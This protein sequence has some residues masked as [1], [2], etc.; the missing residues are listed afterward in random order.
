MDAKRNSADGAA[1]EIAARQHGVLTR[2]QIESCGLGSKAI[3][4]RVRKGQLHRVHQGVYAVGHPAT[5]LHR[6]WMA[7]VLACGMDAALSH[8]SAAVLWGLLKPLD[9]PIHIS[10]PTQRSRRSRRGIVLHRCPSLARQEGPLLLT[11]REGIPVTTVPR[12]IEDLDGLLPPKLV[13]RAMRQA[14]FMGLHLGGVESDRTRSDLEAAFLDL[15]RRHGLPTPE[16]NTK[17]GRWEVDFLWRSQNLVVEADSW[18]YHRGSVAFEDDH[19]R[20]LDLRAQGFTVLRFTDRQLEEEPNGIASD[21][22]RA[23]TRTRG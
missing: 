10:I 7:A 16:V 1:G 19:A 3:T 5:S 2:R 18:T 15:W 14:E 11:R 6:R 20:D 8:G 23:L 4:I 17:L 9:G 12:T 21:V 13:R 22:K